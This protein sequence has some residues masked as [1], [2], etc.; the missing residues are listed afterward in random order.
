MCAEKVYPPAIAED[1]TPQIVPYTLPR[2]SGT[3]WARGL[4]ATQVADLVDLAGELAAIFPVMADRRITQK[5]FENKLK[6]LGF[7][8]DAEEKLVRIVGY[9]S[10]LVS[11][12]YI[13]W[14]YAWVYNFDQEYELEADEGAAEISAARKMGLTEREITKRLSRRDVSYVVN[15]FLGRKSRELKG[16]IMHRT[17]REALRGGAKH[18]DLFFKNVA[19]EKQTDETSVIDPWAMPTPDLMAEIQKMRKDV[20]LVQDLDAEA[21][22]QLPAPQEP[23][24]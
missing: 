6:K 20:G 18:I 14:A 3:A 5:Q 24:E 23:E 21:R 12:Y 22:I 2:D 17:A 8:H 1:Q 13:W 11:L 7:A 16:R 19:D 10:G 9:T 15:L 4:T